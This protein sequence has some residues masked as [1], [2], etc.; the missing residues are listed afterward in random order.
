MDGDISQ[1]CARL[2]VQYCNLVGL[3]DNFSILDTK[4]SVKAL[5][6][7]LMKPEWICRMPRWTRFCG[8]SG[9]AK[10]NLFKL[11]K[12]TKARAEASSV[13]F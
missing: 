13:V 11:P 8:K 4:D 10:S 2:L 6:Q 5:K 12:N 3:A 9:I 7:R 1:L